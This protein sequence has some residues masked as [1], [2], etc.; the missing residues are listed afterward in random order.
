MM[1]D[2]AVLCIV[3]YPIMGIWKRKMLIVEGVSDGFTVQ[4][5]SSPLYSLPGLIHNPPLRALLRGS[6]IQLL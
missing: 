5:E 4:L 2:I 3:V 1:V 6:V